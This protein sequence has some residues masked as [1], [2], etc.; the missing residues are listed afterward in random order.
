VMRA[1]SISGRFGAPRLA[2]LAGGLGWLT[3]VSLAGCFDVHAVDP[4]PLVLD[5]FE[6]AE[7]LPADPAFGVWSCRRFNPDTSEGVTCDR[8]TPGYQGAHSLR[9][10]AQVTDLQNSRM[11]HGGAALVTRVVGPLVDMTRFQKVTFGAKVESGEPPLPAGAQLLVELGCKNVQRD[12]MTWS[13]ASRVTQAA[14]YNTSWQ[15]VSL[16]MRNFISPSYDPVHFAG[17]PAECLVQV[18]SVRFALNAELDD[19]G[20]AELSLW[21]DSI[22]F[23]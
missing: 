10:S 11:D 14:P 20:S 22:S 17:G 1:D 19:G 3:V 23:Q 8:D 2:L 9:L 13:D 5:D 6:G 21:I 4:G 12:D 15:T 7:L 18:D 16:A